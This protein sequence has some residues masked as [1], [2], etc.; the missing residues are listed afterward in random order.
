MFPC[1]ISKGRLLKVN[2][3]NIWPVS[4][5]MRIQCRRHHGATTIDENYWVITRILKKYGNLPLC[6]ENCALFS[7]PLIFTSTLYTYP[8][9]Y[10]IFL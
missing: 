6:L 7:L 2:S 9:R 4:G 1:V 8:L 10:V 5:S 3:V